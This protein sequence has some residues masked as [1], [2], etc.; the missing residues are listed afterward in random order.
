M[1]SLEWVEEF[2]E[3]RLRGG[4]RGLSDHYPLIVE[5]TKMKDVPRPFR[6]LDSWFTHEGFLTMVKEEWRDLGE[7]NFTDKLKVLTA[8]LGRWHKDN[9]G[10]MDK[11]ILQFEEEIEK[12]DDKVSSG[13]YDGTVEARRKALVTYCDRWYIKKELH[14]KQMSRS[15]HAKDMDKNTR[16]FHQIASA[17][18]RNN[19]IDALMINERDGLVTR[20]SKEEYVELE[21]L[22]SVEEIRKA[23]WDCESSKAPGSDV[24]NMNFIKKCCDEIGSEFTAVVIAFFQTAKLPKDANITWVAL[25]PKFV[26]AKEIKYLRP[27]SMVG[28]VY[29][30]ISKVL[31]RRMRAVMPRLIGETQSAFVKGRKIHDGTLIACE[32]VHWLKLRKK[33]AAIIKLDFQKAY[34]R[35]KWSFVDIVLQKMGFGRRLRAWV[36]E[37]V[38]TASMSVLINGSPT[39]PF[40][41]ERGLR[42]GDPISPFLF[43]LVVDILHR[44]IGEVVRNGRISPLMTLP[45]R[46]G[47]WKDICQ[48][49]IK[50]QHVRDKMIT[51]LT[52]EVGDGRRTRF[53]EDVWLCCGALKDRFPRLFSLHDALRLVKLVADRDDRFVWKFDR[54]GV[55]TTNL[56]V[57]VLQEETLLE[58]ITSYSFTKTI[59]KALVPPRVELFA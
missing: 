58:D 37:C 23:V 56:F 26:R 18:R 36:M 24:Y 59:W 29:K 44:M 2:P 30:V 22:P 40:M 55:F 57:Q 38:G 32:T 11:K 21:V 39:K 31:V 53:Q 5:D 25:A 48:L 13:V 8:P 14:W 7:I 42:Q 35:V 52:M 6:S 41:M 50:E 45:T 46:G 49:Q 27:I 43:I 34:D 4:P 19:K 1:V 51:G 15:R 47:P 9:F 54:Q 16:Y 10:D 28:C 17:R 20:I 12:L 33:E 3:T